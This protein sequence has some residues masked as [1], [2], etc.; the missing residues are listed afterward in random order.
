MIVGLKKMALALVGLCVLCISLFSCSKDVEAPVV[1]E[2][3]IDTSLAN[4]KF[5]SNPKNLNVIM[6]VP[7]D[8]PARADYKPR[9]SQLMVHFQSW[10]HDEMK[11]YGYDKYM[12]LAKDEATGLVN[13][14]EIKGAGTQADY[15]YEASVSANKIIKEIESFRT[16]NP[17]LFSSDK[18]YLILL[19][20][21]TSGDTGQPFYGY[22]KYCFALDNA[23]MSV[24]HIPNPNSNY[25]GGMLHELGH[26]LNLPHNRAKYVSEEP[27]LGTSLM[28]SGNVSFSKGKPTFLTEVD[29]AILNVNEVFQ[30]TSSSELA[31]ESPTFTLD[32][33]F[34][35]DN[36]NQRLNISGSF[37][38]DKEVSD[39]LVY[40]DPNVNN[41][42]VGVNRDYNAVAW[43]FNPGTNNTLA[44]AIDLKELFYKGNT[45]YDLKIKLLLKNGANTTTDFG[46]Q[47]VNDELTSFGNVVFTYSNASYAG[48]KGQLDIGEYTKAD[49]LDKGIEDNSI[50]SIKIGHDVK[51]TLYDGDHFSGNSL[52]LTASSTYLSTFN[53]KVSSMKV[54]KK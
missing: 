12:G 5:V 50:S 26:G 38:S 51:V 40:L 22:G 11:R 1:P 41:E 30:S 54:E 39:I 37:T 21:R 27:T 15:P 45:P 14:I 52:V 3:P 53:D 16:A 35:I 10:L 44:G 23:F 31:Y 36:A 34:E 42:G 47:Y 28:G 2:N 20:E 18:H 6:F 43:R 33:K 46:F 29:A 32:P 8:N 48:V 13:I 19:P 49:L 17:Q 25:L 24:N 7:T 4:L 9:L